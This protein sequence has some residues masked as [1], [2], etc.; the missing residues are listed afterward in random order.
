MFAR[1]VLS[2]GLKGTKKQ[3]ETR[4]KDLIGF[5]GY[6]LLKRHLRNVRIE[7]DI[8]KQLVTITKNEGIFKISFSEIEQLVNE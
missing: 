8:E 7:I 3:P 1:A 5:V 6:S 4:L 2:V